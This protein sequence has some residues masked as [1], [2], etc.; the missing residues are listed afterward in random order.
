[1]L[2][3]IGLDDQLSPKTNKIHDVGTNRRLSTKVMTE[4]FQFSESDPQFD[5]LRRQTFAQRTSDFIRHGYPQ[6]ALRDTFPTNVL[7]IIKYAFGQGD[8][9]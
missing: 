8:R 7:H 1:V 6:R 5:F 9:I 4:A 3:T 2:S